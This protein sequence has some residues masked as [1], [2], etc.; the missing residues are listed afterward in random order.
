MNN[1][2]QRFEDCMQ[3]ILQASVTSGGIRALFDIPVSLLTIDTAYQSDARTSRDLTPLING[4]NENKLE[5]ITVVPHMEEGM[6]YIVNGYGRWQASQLIKDPK[7]YLSAIVLLGLSKNPAVRRKEEAELYA[8]Q[9]RESSR[10]TPIQNHAAMLVLEE[11]NVVKLEHLR[12]KYG[13][14]F[15]TKKER[16]SSRPANTIS[17]A[18]TLATIKGMSEENC[19]LIFSTLQDSKYHLIPDGYDINMIKAVKQAFRNYGYNE[20]IKSVIVDILS[21]S[22]PS[23]LDAKAHQLYPELESRR[24]TRIYLQTCIADTLQRDPVFVVE[25]NKVI[26]VSKV[27]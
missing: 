13:F 1:Q 17:Y 14:G 21:S 19:E 24:A 22:S 9:N 3:Y 18:E 8:Y 23:E 11:P 27:S 10:L 5:P 20:D 6:F 2:K 4:W 7:D 16:K 15:C 12:I 25:G 26:N